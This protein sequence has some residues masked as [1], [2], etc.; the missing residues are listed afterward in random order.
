MNIIITGASQGIGYEITRL[1]AVLPETT[2][3]A[4]ARNE[5]KLNQLKNECSI[6]SPHSNVVSVSF[7]LEKIIDQSASI[8]NIILQ[9]V[10]HI[11]ILINNAGLLINK[12]FT[13][14]SPQEARKIFDV[15]LFV[16]ALLIKELFPY[17]GKKNVTHVVNISSM[18]GFQ[19]SSKYPGLSYYSSSKAALASIT[20]CLASEYKDSRVYFNCLALGSVQTDMFAKAFPGYKAQM[21]PEEMA[22][23]IVDF[24]LNGYKHFRGKILP[25][26]I[27]NP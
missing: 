17:M 5:K 20:E 3:I 25:V 6:K 12:S 13:D 26:S 2:V 15:N 22:R 24:A 11:D 27:A 23:F 9:H 21:K 18:A 1:F 10:D 16:P 19:G 8:T 7:D 4:I 14:I